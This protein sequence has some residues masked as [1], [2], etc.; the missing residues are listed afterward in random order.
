MTVTFRASFARDL[1][2][3]RD[4]RLL[5]RVEKVVRALENASS[6]AEIPQLKQLRGHTRLYRVRIGDWRMGL[7][8]DA[9]QVD[10]VRVLHRR[11][12]YRYFP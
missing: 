10:C 5:G 2:T 12:I 1:E 3:I 4:A 8:I 7:H 11:E 9:N 6:P